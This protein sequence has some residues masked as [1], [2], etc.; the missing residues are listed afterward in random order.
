MIKSVLAPSKNAL[1]LWIYAQIELI[2]C[3]NGY[4]IKPRSE[5]AAIA[6]L[7]FRDSTKVCFAVTGDARQRKAVRR[8]ISRRSSAVHQVFQVG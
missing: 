2:Y 8:S 5:V 7:I 3:H 4:I 1:Q 6:R